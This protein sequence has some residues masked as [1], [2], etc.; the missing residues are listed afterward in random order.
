MGSLPI[1]VLS[2]VSLNWKMS[3]TQPA[4]CYATT[5]TAACVS[6]SPHHHGPVSKFSALYPG[7]RTSLPTNTCH[8]LKRS[9]LI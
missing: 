7:A 8:T 5:R 6:N 3:P 9:L 1:T 2:A 4:A